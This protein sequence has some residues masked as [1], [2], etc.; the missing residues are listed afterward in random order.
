MEKDLDFYILILTENY[1]KYVDNNLAGVGIK[2]VMNETHDPIA[3]LEELGFIGGV[4]DSDLQRR[5]RLQQGLY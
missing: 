5:Q 1:P 3:Y 2:T 4:V